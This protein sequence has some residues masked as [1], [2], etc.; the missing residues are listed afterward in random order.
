V[1][2]GRRQEAGG[3]RQEAEGR[4][5]KAGGSLNEKIFSPLYMKIH[6][7]PSLLSRVFASLSNQK[8]LREKKLYSKLTFNI[9]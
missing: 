8:A 4:R 6:L 1:K 3:R 5:Q 9:F 2:E 7:S